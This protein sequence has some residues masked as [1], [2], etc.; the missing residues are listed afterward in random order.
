MTLKQIKQAIAKGQ[1]VNWSTKNYEV[2]KDS[3][4]Q[5]LIHSKCNGNYIGLTWQ[6]DKTLNG[7]E[8]EFKLEAK[9]DSTYHRAVN[10]DIAFSKAIKKQFGSNKSRFEVSRAD[11]NEET[12]EAYKAKLFADIEDLKSYNFL[13]TIGLKNIE[14]AKDQLNQI[15]RK[16]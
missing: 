6:D 15:N 2:I 10:A 7:E 9:K 12:Q 13:G 11:F 14:K 1:V 8:S 4:G 5:Y 3:I 16:D